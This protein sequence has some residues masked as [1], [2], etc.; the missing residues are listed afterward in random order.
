ML[1]EYSGTWRYKDGQL[2]LSMTM[3]GGSRY[4]EG[5]R[6]QIAGTYREEYSVADELVLTRISGSAINDAMENGSSVIFKK[7]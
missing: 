5:Q 7:Q 4:D 3:S 6:G 1:A 2:T